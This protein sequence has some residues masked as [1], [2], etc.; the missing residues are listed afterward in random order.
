LYVF[1]EKYKATSAWLDHW[2]SSKGEKFDGPQPPEFIQR[3]YNERQ[4]AK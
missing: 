4:A 2:A 3:A 1:P